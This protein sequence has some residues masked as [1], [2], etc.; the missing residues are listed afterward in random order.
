[1]TVWAAVSPL[2]G[3]LVG[4]LLQYWV[5][6][7][8]ELGKQAG[9]LRNAAYVDYLRSVVRLAHQSTSDGGRSAAVAEATDAKARIAI[10]GT[11]L[12][13]RAL[14]R[15]EEVGAVLDDPRAIE[16]FVRFVSAAGLNRANPD[17]LKLLLFGSIA[18]LN[19][20]AP[21]L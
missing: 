16:C 21:S 13:V 10:Y 11:K 5:S 2:L 3:V 15:F 6:H 20:R 19:A 9:L 18:G 17:D 8:A 14:A 7:A 4:A 1:M 12:A